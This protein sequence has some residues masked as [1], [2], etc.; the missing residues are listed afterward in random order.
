[1]F[2]SMLDL[3][4]SRSE[5]VV[6]FLVALSFGGHPSCGADTVDTGLSDLVVHLFTSSMRPILN[7]RVCRDYT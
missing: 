2:D 5:L 6:E 3:D 4:T 1:M 7:D